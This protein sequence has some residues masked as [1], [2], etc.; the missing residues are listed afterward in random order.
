MLIK[1]EISAMT[2]VNGISPC[3]SLAFV[4]G[5]DRHGG[6][7]RG[8]MGNGASA[9]PGP[10]QARESAKETGEKGIEEMIRYR[11]EFPAN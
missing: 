5:T 1:R 6:K 10:G 4:G 11:W 8:K 2:E 9:G 3:S 7:M